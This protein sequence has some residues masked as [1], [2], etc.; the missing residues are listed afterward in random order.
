MEDY[1]KE[2]IHDKKFF[3]NE[4]HFIVVPKAGTAKILRLKESEFQ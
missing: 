4:L 3:D 2:I 1:I